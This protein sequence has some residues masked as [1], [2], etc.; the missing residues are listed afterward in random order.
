MKTFRI[1]YPSDPNR[2]GDVGNACLLQPWCVVL[3]D[4]LSPAVRQASPGCPPHMEQ[5]LRLVGDLTSQKDMALSY[6]MI[7]LISAS[8][9]SDLYST[10]NEN[11]TSRLKYMKNNLL[12]KCC[13]YC[14]FGNTFW[15][16]INSFILSNMYLIFHSVIHS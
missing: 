16:V 11:V 3:E 6:K 5:L 9:D 2:N 10:N 7:E 8:P 14:Y 12:Q 15:S 13:N 1:I 4:G